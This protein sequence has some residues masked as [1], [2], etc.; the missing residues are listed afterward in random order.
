MTPRHDTPREHARCILPA[1]LISLTY[2]V[3]TAEQKIRLDQAVW[4]NSQRM[5]GTPCFRGTRVPVRSLI[6]LLE[7]GETIDD[8]L[9]FY[10]S[11]TRQ[12]A[13]AVLSFANHRLIDCLSS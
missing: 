10:P 1:H 2:K 4:V 3:V 12:Q 9:A 13:L 8:F 6:D 7:G 5:S 11:V